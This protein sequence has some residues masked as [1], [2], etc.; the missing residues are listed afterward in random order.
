MAPCNGTQ[1]WHHVHCTLVQCP[2]VVRRPPPLLEVRTP[3][4]IAIWGKTRLWV[5]ACLLFFCFFLHYF[6]L[7]FS[8]RFFVHSIFC[9]F[10]PLK[11]KVL[12]SRISPVLVIITVDQKSSKMM[13]E[14]SKNVWCWVIQCIPSIESYWNSSGSTNLG[15]C[16]DDPRPAVLN[17]ATMKY[18]PRVPRKW[19]RRSWKSQDHT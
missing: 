8:A 3:I 18:P 2:K 17:S 12:V 10:F 13:I 4:A 6:V 11:S 9:F 5:F 19:T 14:T 15:P 1:Q 16:G 7:F